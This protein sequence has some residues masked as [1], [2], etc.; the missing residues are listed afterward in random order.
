[1]VP[2]CIVLQKGLIMSK[3]QI[4]IPTMK[5]GGYLDGCIN[6]IKSFKHDLTLTVV[7]NS[8]GNNIGVAA[9]W[10]VGCHE[11]V[12]NGSD[13]ILILNDDILLSPWTIDFLVKAFEDDRYEEQPLKLGAVA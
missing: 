10:N 12:D 4:V 13:Y 1:M 2:I 7:D 5:V 11:A 3:I 6:S 9:A 8:N